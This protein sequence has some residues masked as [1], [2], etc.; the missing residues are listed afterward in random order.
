MSLTTLVL[1]LVVLVAG[2]AIVRLLTRPNAYPPTD[3]RE[4]DR[5]RLMEQGE[6]LLEDA[7]SWPID[8]RDGSVVLSTS[9]EPFPVRTVHYQVEAD[10]DFETALAYVKNLS[11]CG[12]T[13]RESADKFEETLYDRGRG[14]AEHEWVR[15]SVHISPPPGRN[16]DATV[17]YFQD[18]PDAG[19]YRVA[20][21]SVDSIDG[22]PIA[23]YPRASRFMVHPALYKMEAVA[24]GR[25]R[26]RKVEAVDPC[27]AVGPLLNNYFVSLLFFRKY[28]FEEAKAMRDAL[29]SVG[30]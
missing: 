20:F 14:S 27:G 26:I 16:R 25:V 4:V 5:D 6:Q 15:R 30:R 11:D 3:L 2:V 19:T 9:L 18:R 23:P 13:T 12:E 10:V 29:V 17:V 1:G 7:A 22:E 24:P 28:M 21:R 8:L